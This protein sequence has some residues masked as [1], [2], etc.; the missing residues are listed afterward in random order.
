M[1]TISRTTCRMQH[2]VLGYVRVCTCVCV[3]V[4]VCEGLQSWTMHSSASAWGAGV[5]SAKAVRANEACALKARAA[6]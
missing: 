2:S 5:L 4:C 1:R 3:C 6:L